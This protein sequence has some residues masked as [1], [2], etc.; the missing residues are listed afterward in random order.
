MDGEK[1]E[2]PVVERIDWMLRRRSSRDEIVE[3]F[4]RALQ[5]GSSS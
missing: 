4:G 5:S 3:L 1:S 2:G